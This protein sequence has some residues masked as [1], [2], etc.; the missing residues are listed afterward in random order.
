MFYYIWEKL[1]K[2][3]LAISLFIIILMF[4]H[5]SVLKGK[6]E[7]MSTR[8]WEVENGVHEL[9]RHQERSVQAETK[10]AVA[11][12]PTEPKK[13]V[14]KVTELAT[15]KAFDYTE[16]EEKVIQT[17]PII[18]EQQVANERQELS[19]IVESEEPLSWYDK[20][21]KSNPDLERFI[22]E[23]LISKIGIAILVL[24]IGY[25][26]KFAIDKNWIN[27]MARVGVGIL[28][29]GIVLGFA[30]YLRAQFKA[31]SSV[32]VAGGVSIFYFTLGIAFQE[33]HIFSQ[34]TTFILLALVTAFSIFISLTYDRQE[35]AILSVIGGFAAPLM[36]ST[37]E[38]NYIVLFSYLLLLDTSLLILAFYRNWS[39]LN[40]VT[41]LLT[42][43]MYG[44]WLNQKVLQSAYSE[45][46]PYLGAILFATAFYVVFAL[47]NMINQVKEKQS[48]RAYELSLILSNTFLYFTC[49]MLVLDVYNQ[50][51]KGLFSL[52]LA[53]FNFLIAYVIHRNSKVDKNL[54]FLLLGLGLSFSTLA[55]PLQL[56]GNYITLFWAAEASLLLWLSQK[57][58][59]NI[60][61]F[62]SVPVL[63]LG[64][65]SMLID[66]NQIYAGNLPL[67][68][69]INS[70]CISSISIIISLCVYLRLLKRDTESSYSFMEINIQQR[71]HVQFVKYLLL[72]ILY[73]SGFFECQYHLHLLF[74]FSFQAE[75]F[76]LLYHLLFI[77]VFLH[78]YAKQNGQHYT[79][80]LTAFGFFSILAYS[81]YFGIGYIREIN[82]LIGEEGGTAYAYWVHYFCL[83]PLVH[84]VLLLYP[85]IKQKWYT[86]TAWIFTFLFCF[87]LSAELQW[88][89]LFANITELNEAQKS[90]QDAY[91]L[92]DQMKQSMRK[93]AFPIAWGLLAFVL[94]SFGIKRAYKPL[95]ISALALIGVTIIKLFVYDIKNV[96]EGGKIA[97]FIL[98]GLVLLIISFTYQK[99]KSIILDEDLNNNLDDK[100]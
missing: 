33:Y 94:L 6:L 50:E 37:G 19:D 4:Y 2:M 25:F 31:F 7:A 78:L 80:Y 3:G 14:V 24:G 39:V 17:E 66:W 18:T 5:Q 51:V 49:V 44:I 1:F 84:Q 36:V 99:I 30:H 27:E 97:A 35:L 56:N 23:N 61:R 92:A 67:K 74:P 34:T 54:F 40:G 91:Y 75:S 83:I 41:F 46:I 28:A 77:S 26:V 10:S 62:V 15:F 64:V 11:T 63:L 32:L 76:L 89:G 69:V 68:P 60:Y 20:F 29:G 16:V 38:G 100:G 79:A 22:G 12:S 13:E 59:L 53:I 88:Q 96:S 21:S 70:A 8:I 93:T 57:S 42:A 86:A 55:G 98:L 85:R 82:F 90:F 81:F 87:L 58:Q 47:S 48:F 65:I 52:L 73:F 71:Q 72:P 9:K 95:R 45:F 43:L